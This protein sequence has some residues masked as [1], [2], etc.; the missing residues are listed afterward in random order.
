MEAKIKHLVETTPNDNV[1]G[2]AVRALYW[3]ERSMN[4]VKDDPNQLTLDQL[5]TEAQNDK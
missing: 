3:A 1:L 2:A 4:E 5:I